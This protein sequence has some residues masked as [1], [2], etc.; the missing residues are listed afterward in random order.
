MRH[1]RERA[2]LAP[3]LMLLASCGGGGAA[4]LPPVSGK[5]AH[6][7]SGEPSG[8]LIVVRYDRDGDALPDILTLDASRSPLVIVEAIRGTVDGGGED[9]T[10]A[11]CGGTVAGALGD[12]LRLHLAESVSTGAE[13]DLDLVLDDETVTIT[14]I[15]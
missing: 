7:V 6:V 5:P 10:A 15:E 9:V 1:G 13:T 8:N 3:A 12:V 11:W 14:V 2:W 4:P